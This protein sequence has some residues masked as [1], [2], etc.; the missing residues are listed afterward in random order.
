MQSKIYIVLLI[1]LIPWVNAVSQENKTQ[2]DEPIYEYVSQRAQFPGGDFALYEYLH[3][4]I[5]FS[6]KEIERKKEGPIQV[7]FVVEKNGQIT[8]IELRMGLTK[9]LNNQVIDAVKLMP[10]WKAAKLM[11]KPVRSYSQVKVDFYAADDNAKESTIQLQ[12][13]HYP[14]QRAMYSMEKQRY[15][16]AVAYFSMYLSEYPKDSFALYYRG[17]ALY[18][19]NRKRE[20]CIDWKDSQGEDSKDLFTAFCV[21]MRGVK[22]YSS[23]DTNYEKFLDTL[24]IIEN[25]NLDYDSAAHFSKNPDAERKYFKKKMDPRM[26]KEYRVPSVVLSF[27][28]NSNGKTEN[29]WIVRSYSSSY[30][31]EAIRLIEEMPT[32]E[33]ATKDDKSVKSKLLYK[34]DFNDKST[35][36]GRFI[37]DFFER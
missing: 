30:D 8:H 33:A 26:I 15:R 25:C 34:I 22:Y 14:I 1:I 37:H 12:S 2:T 21:G 9:M 13:F 35:K 17:G 10:S 19:V 4:H 32:W 11:G 29:I 36:T 28:V 5:D 18:N 6:Q 31:Q 27:D 3:N 20:A 16:E 7:N 24:A 23:T